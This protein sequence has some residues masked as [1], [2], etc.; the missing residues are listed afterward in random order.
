MSVGAGRS[1]VLRQL[2]TESV[3]LSLAGGIF[4]IILAIAITRAMV[5]LM[6]EFYVPNEARIT[7]NGY[8]LAFSAGVSILTGIV[9]G[10]APAL[11]CSRL[12]LV[13]TLKDGGKGGGAESPAAAH[14]ACW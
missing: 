14:G 10:L 4:G 6:P 3:A 2:L 12:D 9:F 1:R 11:Q 13:E 8:V 5:A 7:L